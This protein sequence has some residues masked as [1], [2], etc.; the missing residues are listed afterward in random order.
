MPRLLRDWEQDWALAPCYAQ[1]HPGCG[2]CKHAPW[3]G[4]T[5]LLLIPCPVLH[6]PHACNTNLMLEAEPL[7][8]LEQL[9]YAGPCP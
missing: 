2:Y 9:H 4:G 5:V 6:C 1:K 3:S 7:S 8:H